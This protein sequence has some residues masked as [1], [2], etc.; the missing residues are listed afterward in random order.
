MGTGYDL[1]AIPDHD[2]DHLSIHLNFGKKGNAAMGLVGIAIF[3]SAIVAMYNLQ[4][5][6]MTLKD[7]GFTVD[8]FT[9]W[10]SDYRQFKDLARREPDQAVQAK[11]QKILNG[12]HFSLIGIAALIVLSL[13]GRI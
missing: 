10:L 1:A 3:I 6:K 12:L 4:Q 8:P 5:I 13:S 2:M 9:G 7:K 11:Y